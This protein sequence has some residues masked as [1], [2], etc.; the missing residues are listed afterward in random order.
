MPNDPNRPTS[1]SFED[2]RREILRRTTLDY[3][4]KND[5]ENARLSPEALERAAGSARKIQLKVL[6]QVQALCGAANG[7]DARAFAS[8]QLPGTAAAYTQSVGASVKRAT[9]NNRRSAINRL[10]E[11]YEALHQERNPVTTE[12]GKAGDQYWS[13]VRAAATAAGVSDNKLARLHFCPVNRLG[14]TYPLKL[15]TVQ[16]IAA[17]LRI[18]T[19]SLTCHL[20]NPEMPRLFQ[21]ANRYADRSEINGRTRNNPYALT[22]LPPAVQQ[23][24]APYFERK[25]DISIP[26]VFEDLDGNSRARKSRV[27]P[28][29]LSGYQGRHELPETMVKVVRQL[30]CILGFVTLPLE[31]AN[32]YL[33]GLG[34]PVENLRLSHLFVAKNLIGYLEFLRLRTGRIDHNGLAVWV[35]L[36]RSLVGGREAFGR[37]AQMH[38]RD[39]LA[40]VLRDGV[41]VTASAWHRWCDEQRDELDRYVLKVTDG[42]GLGN[43]GKARDPGEK[44]RLVLDYNHPMQEVVW[45][46]VTY[47]ASRRPPLHYPL[48][49]RFSHEEKVFTVAALASEPL[50]RQNWRHMEWGRHLDRIDGQWRIA[51]PPGV[52]KNRRR[53]KES[54]RSIVE[55]AAQQ[56]YE[57]WYRI[58]IENFGYDPLDERHKSKRSYVLGFADRKNPSRICDPN[59]LTHRLAFLTGVWGFAPGPHAF[60]HLW[61]TDWLRRHPDDFFT[62]AGRLNDKIETVLR[63]Y[64]HLRSGDHSVRVNRANAALAEEA[65][66]NLKRRLAEMA[67]FEDD[68]GRDQAVWLTPLS[69]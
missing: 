47:L 12:E 58:W 35:T 31:S 52:F 33:S 13:T 55:P 6:D 16:R 14:T 46:T 10:G 9:L 48:D 21:L 69:L 17:A 25:L 8:H 39:D 5:P 4:L 65:R 38:L 57:A 24:I 20:W 34:V 54:Y 30:R 63:E 3:L 49:V 64:A 42:K 37:L 50:R 26:F 15:K 2:L 28:W 18:P 1:V 36:H 51:I 19:E 27:K 45:P 60:R 23:A 62:V 7:D 56:Y 40:S 11:H 68:S 67:L 41:P 22:A 61:A 32:V 59:F 29:T 66:E 44:L 43:V 53:L